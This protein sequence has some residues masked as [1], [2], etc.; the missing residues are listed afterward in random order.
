M[1]FTPELATNQSHEGTGDSGE[2]LKRA[3]ILYK[4]AVVS[5]SESIGGSGETFK[6]A[7]STVYSRGCTYES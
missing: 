7:K 1:H 2:T 3:K 6:R 4:V 5:T